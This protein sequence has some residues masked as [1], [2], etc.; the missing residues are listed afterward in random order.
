M[1]NYCIVWKNK[2]LVSSIYSFF[3]H[4]FAPLKDELLL[5][6]FMDCKIL[7]VQHRTCVIFCCHLNVYHNKI[8]RQVLV[9]CIFSFSKNL[10]NLFL[11]K[12]YLFTSLQYRSLENTVGKGKFAWYE[13]FFLFPRV[14]YPS[15]E[16]SAIF[17]KSKIVICKL[18][19]FRRV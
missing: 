17:I 5:P 18:I 2:R 13:H 14:F 8:F 1:D 7:S 10:F 15:G 9:P 16:L 12:P 4:A 11:N 19:Q 3:H 6:L